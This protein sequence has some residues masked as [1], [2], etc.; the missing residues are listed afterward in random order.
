MPLLGVRLLL[1]QCNDLR[2]LRFWEFLL[3]LARTIQWRHTPGVLRA[4]SK[5][6]RFN[7]HADYAD[8]L[9]LIAVGAIQA[10]RWK[11]AI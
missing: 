2:A 7:M 9:G 1:Q 3:L 8:G 11:N 5:D 10:D 4:A 6:M